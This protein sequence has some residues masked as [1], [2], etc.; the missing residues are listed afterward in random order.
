MIEESKVASLAI[1]LAKSLR[2][3]YGQIS[4][5]ELARQRKIE[6][7]SEACQMAD[8]RIVYLAECSLDPPR[9][10][11]NSRAIEMMAGRFGLDL[12]QLT[13]LV[14][15]HE[16]FHILAKQPSTSV[17][18]E[19]AAHAFAQALTGIHHALLPGN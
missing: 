18:A 17:G 1:S 16:L 7:K 2:Q 11:L 9:I 6:V 19:G 4:A 13:E 14:L 12:W 5:A 10:V 15:A 8:D 3:Q